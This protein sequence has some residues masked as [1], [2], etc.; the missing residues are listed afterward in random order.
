MTDLVLGVI[1]V[2]YENEGKSPAARMT[3]KGRVH[4]SDAMRI[5][6][7][8]SGH[9]A[10]GG[11]ATTMKVARWL[12]EKYGVMQVF[13]DAHKDDITAALIDSLSGALENL[14]AGAPV[15]DPFAEA[16]QVITRDFRTFLLSGEIEGLGVEG[17]P[18]QAALERR[19]LRFKSGRSEGPRPSF[20]DTA[21]Y[22]LAMRSWIDP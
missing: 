20:I 2:P 16:G 1:D 9:D 3:K 10:N 6:R 17:V 11:P 22:E 21:T 15:G 13:F 12:E 19:S 8:M 18:T 4:H 14:H 5:E 7:E